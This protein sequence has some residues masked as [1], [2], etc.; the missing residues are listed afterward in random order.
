M[1]PDSALVEMREIVKRYPDVLAVD[2]ASLDIQ[3]A[4]IVGLVGKNGAGKST[5]IKILS[6]VESP[7]SGTLAVEGVPI[8]GKSPDELGFSFVYQ[9]LLDVP[10]LSVAVNLALASGLPR[11]GGAF[12]DWKALNKRS[13]EVLDKLE[14]KVSPSAIVSTLG[15]VD[16]RMVMIAAALYRESRL[17]VLDEPTASLSAPE[18]EKLH[19]TLRA[20]RGHGVAILYVSH[21]LEEILEFCDRVVVMRDGREVA[22]E[23]VA[24]IDKPKLVALI[25]GQTEK[26]EKL[27]EEI[28]STNHQVGEELLRVEG[29]SRDRDITDISFTLRE[30]EILGLAGLVGS[31]RTELA[32]LIVGED[33]RTDGEI[34]VKGKRVRISSPAAALHQGIV[35]LPEN[36]ADEGI[37]GAFGIRQNLTLASLSKFRHIAALPFTSKPKELIS[38]DEYMKKLDIR[39]G[40]AEKPI[41]LLS[42]GNQQKVILARWLLHG[43]EILIFDEPT[44]GVDIHLKED[45]FRRCEELASSG[46]GIIFI[47]SELGE[48]QRICS[49]VLVLRGGRVVDELAGSEITEETMLSASFGHHQE[50]A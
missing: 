40:S 4:E 45:I 11:R 12:V 46:K 24:E 8:A 19:A 37:I 17:I 27:R 14:I 32:R 9:E 48:L 50:A 35:L 23:T 47:S 22:N 3:P 28:R 26:R 29:Y 6:G 49:R 18:V 21:R 44:H 5:M 20:L 10:E 34:F 41:G 39:A 42:G 7:D 13:Q 16:R 25:G 43:A 31:G 38:S 15:A 36:R 1:S 30:G 33:K 2:G